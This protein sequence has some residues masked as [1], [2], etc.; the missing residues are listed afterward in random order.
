MKGLSLLIYTIFLSII[1]FVN[2][3]AFL[4]IA[5]SL[6][7]V[8]VQ[9]EF[10][11]STLYSQ[12]QAQETFNPP[13]DMEVFLSNCLLPSHPNLDVE[14]YEIASERCEGFPSVLCVF[15]NYYSSRF[16]FCKPMWQELDKQYYF[17][18]TTSPL[19]RPILLEGGILTF[20]AYE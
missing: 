4:Q 18:G 7:G 10:V 5:G 19:L 3:S 6:N 12:I 9:V 14:D 17:N 15:Y 8:P 11:G 1:F 20:E 2:Q 16:R 13:K